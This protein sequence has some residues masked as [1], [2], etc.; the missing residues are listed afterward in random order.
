M[1]CNYRSFWLD[2]RSCICRSAERAAFMQKDGNRYDL[3][4]FSLRFLRY[5]KDVR[6]RL[7]IAYRRFD[8]D[9]FRIGLFGI[10]AFVAVDFQQNSFS[11]RL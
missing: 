9:V 7:R 11:L 2:S 4:R 6:L 3:K 8:Y 5:D 10:E 1:L